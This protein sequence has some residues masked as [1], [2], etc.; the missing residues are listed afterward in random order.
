MT[1]PA[2]HRLLDH[3][4]EVVLRLVAP[5][6]RLLLEE[7]ARALRELAARGEAAPEGS[8]E[9][10]DEGSGGE[11]GEERSLAGSR[12]EVVLEGADGGTMLVQWLNELVFLGETE[13]WLPT[14]V[15]WV[16]PAGPAGTPGAGTPETAAGE[17][18][19]GTARAGGG[20]GSPP[21]LPPRLRVRTRGSRLPRPFVLVKAATLHDLVY[22][23]GP[24]GIEA[25]VT[26]DL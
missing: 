6:F 11:G 2:G 16:G 13:P 26:L 15:E 25:E 19:G 22:R 21:T 8:R 3:T 9:T 18:R 5:D 7:A 24:D 23:E 4:S 14:E 17:E 20:E 12:R 1:A 10:G